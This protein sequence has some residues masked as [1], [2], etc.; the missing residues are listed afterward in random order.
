M[1]YLKPGQ[2][3]QVVSP[4][5]RLYLP[6]HCYAGGQELEEA[7][8]PQHCLVGK[9]RRLGSRQTSFEISAL[10]FIGYVP[11]DE[12]LESHVLHLC[13]KNNR[14]YVKALLHLTI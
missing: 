8:A 5:P 7:L 11:L 4:F 1:P 13:S 14:I 6:A 3:L 2:F 10:T 12:L 9:D